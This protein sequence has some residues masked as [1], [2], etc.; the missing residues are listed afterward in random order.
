MGQNLREKSRGQAI[1]LGSTFLQL[2]EGKKKGGGM[3]S[4]RQNL[5]GFV[6]YFLVHYYLLPNLSL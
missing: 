1:L 2:R 4:T 5:T 3:S 6:V